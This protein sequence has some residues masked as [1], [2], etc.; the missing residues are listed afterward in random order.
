M[1][2]VLSL[3]PCAL[4]F[5]GRAAAGTTRRAS[6]FC[7]CPPPAF[8]RG[9]SFTSQKRLARLAVPRMACRQTTF[10]G[11]DLRELFGEVLASSGHRGPKM[12]AASRPTRRPTGRERRVAAPGLLVVIDEAGHP[13]ASP[14]LA[15][16]RVILRAVAGS[17]SG[18]SP[19][20]R[21]ASSCAQ[22][23]D[24]QAVHHLANDARHPARSR[25]IHKR[26]TTSPTTRVILRAVAGSMLAN[27]A[28]SGWIPHPAT[29]RR[30]TRDVGEV[31]SGL[32]ILRLRAG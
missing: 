22:S 26:D 21:R 32:W 11:E 15:T 20:Q 18:T 13:L 27:E 10:A 6:L 9:S 29:A 5:A 2:C 19:R 12:P 28:V 30:M 25:R 7:S 24:P 4:R 23:Q 3:A 8:R 1:V 14:R 17:I 31:M 16:A